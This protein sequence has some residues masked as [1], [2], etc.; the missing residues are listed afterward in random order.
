LKV[1][2]TL[3]FSEI[4]KNHAEYVDEFL[5]SDPQLKAEVKFDLKKLNNQGQRDEDA[6]EALEAE[7]DENRI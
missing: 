1:D 2:F 7:Q 4:C 3:F 5:A 6:D